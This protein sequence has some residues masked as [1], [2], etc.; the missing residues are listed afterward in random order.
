MGLTSAVGGRLLLP[1]ISCLLASGV[2][3]VIGAIIYRLYFHPLSKF[4][5]PFWAKISNLYGGYHAW[6]GDL[7]VD[8]WRCHEQYGDYV[9]YAPN[10]LMIN[11]NTGLKDIYSYSKSFQK[12]EVYHAMVHRAPNT[13]TCV[14][15]K[16]HGRK[17]R[18]I[19]QGFSDSALRGFENTILTHIR[20]LCNQ[21]EADVAPQKMDSKSAPW[22]EGQNM[23]KWSNYLTFDIMSDVIFGESYALLEKPDNRFVIKAIEDSNIRTSVLVQAAE[24]G[25]RRLDRYLFPEAIIARNKFISFVSGLLKER[26]A[27]KP[28]KRPDVFSFLLDAKDPETQQGLGMAEIGAE[29]TTM[30]VAGSDTTSTAIAS[31]FFYLMHNPECYQKAAAEVRSVFA[32]HEDVHLGPA[33]NSCVYL[34]AC[35]DESMRMSPPA[36]VAPWRE[37]L[38]GGVT[39]DGHFIP[40]GCDVGT[41]IY[42]IH[43]NAA[44]YPEPFTFSPE[45]WCVEPPAGSLKAP[46]VVLAQSA[47][48]PF[49]IGPRGCVGKGLANT[50]L[51]LTMATMLSRFDI[52]LADGPEG[53]IGCGNSDAEYGRH[54]VNE[55]QL[56]DHITAAKNG[57]IVQFRSRA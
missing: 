26:M 3:Y 45:R 46:S 33:L 47:F 10:R 42:A 11:T 52:K 21:V 56:D 1:L 8:M 31:S 15:K 18:I 9:R 22:S 20:K 49:S 41:S 19:S 16:K 44:Y 2:V 43:H 12:S 27:A 53:I 23:G 35:I 38:E 17:R 28:I 50:E 34:R 4:P 54:R 29:S 40:R 25:F 30:I 14:D 24:I 32:S 36:A 51:M 55:Y 37:V 57:P 7:H 6:K 13:L 5:G 39:I 48:N